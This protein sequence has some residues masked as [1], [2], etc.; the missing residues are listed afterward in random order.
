MTM[1]VEERFEF[2]RG[3]LAGLTAPE[4]QE[5]FEILLSWMHAEGTAA[6]NNPMATTYTNPNIGS[7]PLPGNTAGVQEYDTW[8]WGLVATTQTLLLDHYTRIVE[9]LRE[10]STSLAD[11]NADELVQGELGTW[12]GYAEATVAAPGVPAVEETGYLALPVSPATAGVVTSLMAGT[13]VPVAGGLDTGGIDSTGMVEYPVSENPGEFADPLGIP[14][15]YELFESVETND[16]YLDY[17]VTTEGGAEAH[18]YFV[19]PPSVEADFGQPAYVTAAQ[20]NQK[21][22]DYVAGGAWTDL[23]SN[24]FAGRTWDQIIEWAT[25]KMHLIGTDAL[26]DPGVMKAVATLI[27][28]GTMIDEAELEGLLRGT[29]WFN[30]HT[31]LQLEWTGNELSQAEKDQRIGTKALELANTMEYYIG[32]PVDTHNWYVQTPEGRRFSVEH[33]LAADPDIHAQA[34]AIAS[35]AVTAPMVVADF[36]KPLALSVDENDIYVYPNN[37]HLRRLEDEERQAGARNSLVGQ[38]QSQVRKLYEAQGIQP[39]KGQIDR[40]AEP[41]YM[42]TTTIDLAEE[43][44]EAAG[45]VEWPHKPAGLDWKTWA[46]PYTAAYSNILELATPTFTNDDLRTALGNADQVPNLWQFKQNLRQ[47]PRWKDTKNARDSYYGTF[48][49]IGRL[50]GFG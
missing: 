49:K 40:W 4:T 25:N 1:S 36:I 21:A 19:V 2:A 15:G 10:G 30:D 6:G 13:P 23:Q 26:S 24:D 45:L 37:P 17:T 43:G 34:L 32:K 14:S 9:L 46:D 31:A 3:V 20:W 50:M 42:N 7:S 29:Q 18:V 28:A 33:L 47:D 41:L 22:A 12:S 44:I 48:G 39:T 16:K 11:F 5:N 38:W 35:G 8:A 27:G